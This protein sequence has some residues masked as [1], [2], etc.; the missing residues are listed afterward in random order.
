[1]MPLI[2]KHKS[3]NE[4]ARFE[5]L[6]HYRLDFETLKYLEMHHD[7]WLA[8]PCA[9]DSKLKSSQQTF[10]SQGTRAVSEYLDTEQ[11]NI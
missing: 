1:M 10:L 3:Q 2:I 6:L 4:Q 8:V 5:N 11:D 7:E 9:F